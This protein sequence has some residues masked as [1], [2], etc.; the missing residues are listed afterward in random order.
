M[1]IIEFIKNIFKNN[2]KKLLEVNTNQDILM[3]RKE[4]I[5]EYGFKSCLNKLVYE[6][7]K[8]N[9]ED[10]TVSVPEEYDRNDMKL[11]IYYV[12]STMINQDYVANINTIEEFQQIE[13]LE[14]DDNYRCGV[15]NKKIL[16]N[17]RNALAHKSGSIEMDD[18]SNIIISNCT[19]YGD[20]IK[21]FKVKIKEDTLIEIL[22]KATLNHRNSDNNIIKELF[23]MI[24]DLENNKSIKNKNGSYVLLLNLLFSF[25]KESTFDKYMNFSNVALD[26]SFL[27][28]KNTRFEETDEYVNYFERNEVVPV[29]LEEE[30]VYR[31]EEVDLAK[32]GIFLNNSQSNKKC[33]WNSK[34]FAFDEQNKIYIP[35]EIV[36]EHIRN[37]LSHGYI[38][39]DDNNEFVIYDKGRPTAPKYFEMKISSERINEIIETD[40]FR[41]G[42]NIP[43]KLHKNEWQSYLYR[44]ELVKTH[45]SF[46]DFIS[47][48]INKFPGL[49]VEEVIKYMYDNNKFSTYIFEHPFAIREYWKYCI[50]GTHKRLTEYIAE[51]A[52]RKD[53]DTVIIGN[54]NELYDSR[55]MAVD[56]FYNGFIK[57][58]DMSYFKALLVHYTNRY[59]IESVEQIESKYSQEEVKKFVDENFI[60]SLFMH[61]IND[62]IEGAAIGNVLKNKSEFDRIATAITCHDKYIIDKCINDKIGEQDLIISIEDVYKQGIEYKMS[63]ELYE[64]MKEHKLEKFISDIKFKIGFSGIE[65]IKRIFSE[66]AFWKAY[67]EFSNYL[68]KGNIIDKINSMRLLEATSKKLRENRKNDETYNR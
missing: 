59:S 2:N 9:I 27:T 43:E 50:P 30:L 22:R 36:L 46:N 17:I 51:L 34:K 13:F 12:I 1:K 19:K 44:T 63:K 28:V 56:S 58:G 64:Y 54:P 7:A 15:H 45:S 16:A 8:M 40:Y 39:I 11:F 32:K 3:S 4:I 37:A 67:G 38:D 61:S 48:Y 60:I 24:D 25:N 10:K 55:Q 49:S 31:K 29:T 62:E 52:N 5:K 35:N 33:L 23:S 21:R 57:K 41:E 53:Q 18:E 66:E 20:T 14:N 65:M 6:I 26:L 47:L 68:R 42:I